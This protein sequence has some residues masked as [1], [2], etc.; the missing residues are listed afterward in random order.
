MPGS[1]YT[2]VVCPAIAPL[3]LL[4]ALTR[5]KSIDALTLCMHVQGIPDKSIKAQADRQ[6]AYNKMPALSNLLRHTY[7]PAGE[8]N[9]NN[10]VYRLILC[11]TFFYVQPAFVGYKVQ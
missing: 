3:S 6:S 5:K 7:I 2:L 11:F 4:I 8:L 9:L 10:F 1:L